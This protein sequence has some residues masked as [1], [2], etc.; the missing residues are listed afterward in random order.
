MKWRPKASPRGSSKAPPICCLQRLHNC[1]I[2]VHGKKWNKTP[3][4]WRD[5]VFE[6]NH[7]KSILEWCKIYSTFYPCSLEVKSLWRCRQCKK[8]D[9]LKVSTTFGSVCTF[10]TS[11]LSCL[12]PV[13]SASQELLLVWECVGSWMAWERVSGLSWVVSCSACILYWIGQKVHVGFPT[14]WNKVF[15]QA[16]ILSFYLSREHQHFLSSSF[17]K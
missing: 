7:S 11:S 14:N 13:R 4:T 10:L 15:G 12:A 3:K 2:S 6:K 1:L 9:C 8:L 16:N 17:S 5:D